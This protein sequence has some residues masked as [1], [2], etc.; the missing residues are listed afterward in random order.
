MISV[1]MASYNGGKFIKQQLESI[2]K[3][4]STDDEVIISDDSSTD[5]TLKV[6]HSLNDNRIK[7]ISNQNFKN[8][9]F[10]F[11]NALKKANGEFI[12]LADQDDIWVEGK[13][14][15]MTKLLC[16]YDM[17]VTDHS[18]INEEGEDILES[19]F[20]K[21]SSGPGVVKNLVKNTYFGCCMAFRAR[22]LNYALPFPQYIPMHD[23]WLGFVADLFFKVKFID[24]PYTKYRKH[25]NNAS[26]ATEVVSSNNL[27]TKIKYRVNIIRYIP[28]LIYRKLHKD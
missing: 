14:E 18:I 19:Y 7:I 2:L 8:P 5:D 27:R 25:S 26:N 15:H 4:L 12:F 17:V 20:L 23:I 11:E 16:Q 13:V 28:N 21:V 10:N 3:Q 9:I 1:C 22:V 6:I 24:H